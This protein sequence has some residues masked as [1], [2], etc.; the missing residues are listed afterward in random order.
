MF[1]SKR[2]LIGREENRLC[3]HCMNFLWI[4]EVL[5]PQSPIFLIVEIM[6][7]DAYGLIFGWDQGM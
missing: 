5:N 3:G 7:V 4:F 2:A 1:N 6:I